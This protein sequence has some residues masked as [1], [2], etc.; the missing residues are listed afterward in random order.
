M[1]KIRSWWFNEIFQFIPL[2]GLSFIPRFGPSS[3]LG[4]INSEDCRI[5]VARRYGKL[6]EQ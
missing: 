6:E 3:S 1:V 4:R 2:F 5:F